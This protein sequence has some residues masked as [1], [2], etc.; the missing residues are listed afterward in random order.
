MTKIRWIL[1]KQK[2][3]LYDKQ[4]IINPT[5]LHNSTLPYLGKNYRI[6]LIDQNSKNNGIYSKYNNNS[7]TIEFNNDT[8]II[9]ISKTDNSTNNYTTSK[10]QEKI[11]SLYEKWIKERAKILFIPKI[12]KFSH[13]IGVSPQSYKIK[14]LR[15]R[16]GSLTKKGTII[17]N[18][19]LMKAPEEIIDYIIIHELCH[20][21]IQGHSFHFWNFLKRY[22]SDYP[23]RIDWLNTNGKYLL[24]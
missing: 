2:D 17:L 6:K 4:E 23:K 5:F 9:I 18:A 22:E 24:H 21:K 3:Y 11:K 14:F 19:N 8:F 13:D 10:I 12:A 15:N 20:L 7:D 1:K 16:W